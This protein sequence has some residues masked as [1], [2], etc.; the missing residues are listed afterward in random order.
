MLVEE[1]SR[2]GLVCS[3]TFLAMLEEQPVHRSVRRGCGFTQTTRVIAQAVHTEVT[4]GRIDLAPLFDRFP[5]TA[6]TLRTA[7]TGRPGAFGIWLRLM[8]DLLERDGGHQPDIRCH[9]EESKVG[10][11][12]A[13]EKF[14]LELAHGR[15]ARRS[16]VRIFADEDGPMLVEKIRMGES[17]SA[18]SLRQISVHGVRVPAGSLFAVHHELPEKSPQLDRYFGEIHPVRDARLKFLRLTTLAIE[19]E[20]RERVFSIQFKRQLEDGFL[21]PGHATLNDLRSAS[22][23]LVDTAR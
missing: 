3:K 22:L 19:P 11:C 5:A 9:D 17:Y 23:A 13:A 1:L 18:T 14:F 15:C 2:A 16:G 12:S 10:T 8:S 21:R 20:E 6:P 7:S 4:G